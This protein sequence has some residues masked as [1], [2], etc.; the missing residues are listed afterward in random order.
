MA[1]CTLSN[2][3]IPVADNSCR[4]RTVEVGQQKDRT[5]RGFLTDNHRAV[6]RE[7]TFDVPLLEPADGEAFALWI[8]GRKMWHVGFDDGIDSDNGL[9]PDGYSGRLGAGYVPGKAWQ[10]VTGTNVAYYSVPLLQGDSSS[11]AAWARDITSGTWNHYAIVRTNGV[12]TRYKN[13]VSSAGT[14]AFSLFASDTT[15]QRWGMVGGT[16]E[17]A[18]IVETA[19]DEVVVA[20]WPFTAAMVAALRTQGLTLGRVLPP[21]PVHEMRGDI[22]REAAIGV[23]ANESPA[24]VRCTSVTDSYAQ[25]RRAGAAGWQ[26]NLRTLSVTLREV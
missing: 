18:P 24:F 12:N 5:P 13:G 15:R 19:F 10:L 17:G 20:S 3:T 22:L 9:N 8:A 23:L 1:F 26:N 2:L 16:L 14:W 7:W 21:F 11:F 6:K 4:M 25:G